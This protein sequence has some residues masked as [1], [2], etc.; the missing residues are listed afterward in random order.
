MP[1]LTCPG[2]H[3]ASA[4]MTVSARALPGQKR[5]ITGAGKLGFARVPFGATMWIGGDTIMIALVLTALV[6]WVAG[7]SRSSARMP[8]VENARKA[9]MDKYAKYLPAGGKSAHDV[10]ED[11]AR[12]D[13]YNAWLAAMSERDRQRQGQG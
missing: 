13:A 12:L 5:A 8:W 9:N 6:P 11:E 1:A 4:F 2:T 3:C 7:R 10:D